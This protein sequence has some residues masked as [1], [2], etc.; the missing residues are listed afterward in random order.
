[1]K[2]DIL[3]TESLGLRGLSCLVRT[4]NR[5][6]LFDPGVSLGYKRHGL[7][8]HPAQVAVGAGARSSIISALRGATDVVFSHFHGDHVPLVDANPYQM[9]ARDVVDVLR[10]VRLWTKD[11]DGESDRIRGRIQSLFEL[12]DRELRNAAGQHSGPLSFSAPVPHGQNGSS[13]GNVMMTRVQE[14]GDVFVHASDIQLLN[15]G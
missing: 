6:I 9:P 10:H 1:M 13:Q 11:L 7:L 12:L 15:P 2:I 4:A 8:P 5:H 3:G 14:A